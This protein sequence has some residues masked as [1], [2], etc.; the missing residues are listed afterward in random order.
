MA[1]TVAIMTS[2]VSSAASKDDKINN[3]RVAPAAIQSEPAGSRSGLG[4][5]SAQLDPEVLTALYALVCEQSPAS[6]APQVFHD[7]TFSAPK[8]IS[9]RAGEAR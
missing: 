2:S 1:R 9:L 6:A 4:T 3:G 5:V 7:V 8:T